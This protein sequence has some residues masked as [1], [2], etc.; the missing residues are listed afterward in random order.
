VTE[1]CDRR[2][3]VGADGAIYLLPDDR[4]PFRI[5]LYN[6]DGSCAAVSYNGSRCLGRHAVAARIA[7]SPFSFASDAGDI[8]VEVEGGIVTLGVP[9]PTEARLHLQLAH[10]GESIPAHFIVAGVPYLVLYRD[11]LR[12]PWVERIPWQLRSHPDFPGKTNVAVVRRVAPGH[13]Q[14]RFFER[15][16]D[17]E[18]PSSGSG[19]VAVAAIAALLHDDPSPIVIDCAGGE[20]TISFSR[21]TEGIA[22]VSTA[23][24]VKSVCTG[25]YYGK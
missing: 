21:Q 10:E 4:L 9:A 6:A 18:T 14:A 24:L 8:A 12:H 17:E 2:Q 5:L 7:A 3:G 22:G 25:I 23:G 11:D 19:C 16:V 1:L 15:G 13:M 20:F